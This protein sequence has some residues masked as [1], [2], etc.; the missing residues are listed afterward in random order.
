MMKGITPN[1]P[2]IIKEL[3]N[4]E[5]LLKVVFPEVIPEA[6]P[7]SFGVLSSLNDLGEDPISKCFSWCQNRGLSQ[8][9]IPHCFVIPQQGR[10]RRWR[11]TSNEN[12]LSSKSHTS[13][14]AAQMPSDHL[15]ALLQPF[16]GHV[17]HRL[18]PCARRR[19]LPAQ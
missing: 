3:L 15:Q 1:F 5:C 18:N 9:H 4:D 8:I 2:Y 6:F 11:R 13:I 12:G 14:V 7:R 10:N 16:D 17:D 19:F